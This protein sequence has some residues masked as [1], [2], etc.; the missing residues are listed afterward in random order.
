M[1]SMRFVSTGRTIAIISAVAIYFYPLLIPSNAILRQFT[2]YHIKSRTSLLFHL[3][4]MR[5]LLVS[6]MRFVST[7]RTI[8]IISAVAIYFYPLLILSNAILRQFTTYHIKSRTLL[9]FYLY[10]MRQLL[11]SPMRF[12]STG[13]TIAIIPTVTINIYFKLFVFLIS[14]IPWQSAA[15]HRT[16]LFCI[17]R[18]TFFSF[19]RD[20]SVNLFLFPRN[21]ST[22]TQINIDKACSPHTRKVD[23]L[24]VYHPTFPALTS[25]V[26]YAIS[27]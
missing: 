11:V 22:L 12:V 3:Y 8:T 23:T 4:R 6:P 14:T 17:R 24:A 16:L 10:R 13:R 7:G 1:P 2:T 15:K 18:V 25:I 26:H 5:Q 20:R 19:Y 27:L 9:L 21:N